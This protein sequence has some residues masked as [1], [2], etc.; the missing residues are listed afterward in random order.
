MK[1][2]L[3]ILTLTCL[4]SCTGGGYNRSYIISDAVEERSEQEL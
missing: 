4:C 2:I 1:T 3:F